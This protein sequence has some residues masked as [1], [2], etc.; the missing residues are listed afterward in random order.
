LFF[1]LDNSKEKTTYMQ[2]TTQTMLGFAILFCVLTT[3]FAFLISLFLIKIISRPI[4]EYIQ[5]Q[6]KITDLNKKLVKISRQAGMAEVSASVLHNVGNVLNSINVSKGILCKKIKELKLSQL[7]AIAALLKEHQSELGSF[8]TTNEKGKHVVEYLRLLSN[9]WE[10]EQ[11][12]LFDELDLLNKN[13][14]HIR[15]VIATQ[16]SMS[17]VNGIIESILPG[18]IIHDILA[19]HQLSMTA[20]HIIVNYQDTINIPIILD[21][22][23]LEQILI[24][25]IR[26][27]IDSLIKSNNDTKKLTIITSINDENNFTIYVKDNGQGIRSENLMKIFTFGFTTKKEGHGFGLHSSIL[28]AKEMGGSLIATSEGENKGATFTLTLPLH[29]KETC[30]LTVL[31]DESPSL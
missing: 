28:A 6:E 24:N 31:K 11:Q 18:E 10:K 30:E 7:A 2:K 1:E 19:L 4:L 14:E 3:L 20:H 23:K 13:I 25:L 17:K 9:H 8:F 16:Q 5:S 29:L 26:N 22:L 15:N 12:I 27:S 21:K